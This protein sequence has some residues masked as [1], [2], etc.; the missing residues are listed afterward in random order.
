[1]KRLIA[2]T[3]LLLLVAGCSRPLQNDAV[4]IARE[5]WKFTQLGAPYYLC[6]IGGAAKTV[7]ELR[8]IKIT[9][10]TSTPSEADKL[11]GVDWA[12]EVHLEAGALRTYSGEP[13]TGTTWSEWVSPLQA[14]LGY[15]DTL[16]VRKI[17]GKWEVGELRPANVTFKQVDQSDLPK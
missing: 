11:N 17:K 15:V 2:L 1:M 12:G 4:T 3:M 13:G 9:A 6:E 16:V 8:D 7:F 14:P 5:H 10:S